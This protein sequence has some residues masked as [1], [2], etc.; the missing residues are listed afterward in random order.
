M[1]HAM[2]GTAT[3]GSEEIAGLTEYGDIL[4]EVIDP[5]GYPELTAAVRENAFGTA[6]QWIDDA[7]FIF[8]LDLLLDGIQALIARGRD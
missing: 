5:E 1:A 7:D 8:G 2:T 3:A 6:E 4:A